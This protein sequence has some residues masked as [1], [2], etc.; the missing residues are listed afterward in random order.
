MLVRVGRD[1]SC[2]HATHLHAT[3][4]WMETDQQELQLLSCKLLHEAKLKLSPMAMVG[5]ISSAHNQQDVAEVGLLMRSVPLD[6]F[7]HP[8]IP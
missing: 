2:R 3:N 7:T 1:C 4:L 8:S 5:I 6:G